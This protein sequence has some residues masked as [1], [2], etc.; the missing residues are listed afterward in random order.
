[1]GIVWKLQYTRRKENENSSLK[2]LNS[3]IVVVVAVMGT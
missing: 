2:T 1:M 3:A